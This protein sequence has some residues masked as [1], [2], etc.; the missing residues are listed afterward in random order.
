MNIRSGKGFTLIELMVVV[1]I[2]ALLAA[3]AI[4]KY[5]ELLEKA[6]LGATLGNL[7]SLRSSISIYYGSYMGYPGTIDPKIQPKMNE[8]IEGELP[9]VKAHY[10]QSNPPYGNSITAVAV[11]GQ[12]PGSMGIGWFYCNADG[13]VYINSIANDIKGNPY[14]I[15]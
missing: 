7:A 3:V 13:T 5:G 12:V 4:P 14:T 6:N 11:L 1:G 10:P 8:T 2:I 9:Y 15:Y